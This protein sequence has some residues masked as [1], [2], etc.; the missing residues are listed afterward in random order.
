MDERMVTD[1]P[2]YNL[3]TDPASTNTI[4]YPTAGST[5][6]QVTVGMYEVSKR[7]L[8][9][10]QTGEPKDKYLTNIEWSPDARKIYIAEVNR[11]QNHMV[12][13]CYD[14]GTTLP[15]KKLF[16]EKHV[17]YVEP[18]NPVLFVPKKD[19]QF[20]WQ[21]ERDGYNHLYLYNTNGKLIR[22]L[23]KGNWVVTRILG[24]NEKGTLLFFESTKE[25]PLERHIYSVDLENYELRKLTDPAGT[26]VGNLNLRGDLILDNFNSQSVP[27]NISIVDQMAVVKR[28]VFTA[29]D[30]LSDF[31]LGET[32]ILPLLNNG[33]V[34]YYRI[35][36]PPNFDKNKKYP[37]VDY[38]YGGPHVQLITNTWLGGSNLWMQYMA[39]QGFVVFTIDGRGSANRGFDFESAVHRQLGTLEMDDQLAGV[40]ELKKLPYVNPDKMAVHGWSF[41]GFMTTTLM[42]RSPGTFKVGIAGGPVIDWRLYEIMYTE[43]YMDSPLE[44]PVGYEQSN[45]LLHV[46]NLKNK[47][48]MIHGCDDDVVLW[49]HSLQYC[50]AAVDAGNTWLDYYVYPGHKH[51]VRGKDR[52]HLMDK[53]TQYILDNL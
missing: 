10:L 23:T 37:V 31:Q 41:G 24:I 44:N 13:N 52:I 18:E 12:L 46:S 1:Y 19:N 28:N 48:L 4:K 17:K 39:Q 20:I 14:A 36:T 7:Q 35:I 32:R 53:V 40:H 45:L 29:P 47:L 49:Q 15:E 30:P 11:E 42:T 33:V 26:H 43:R 8:K 22:Q 2:I 5:S 16:E 21:S 34:L 50:K 27:R 25:S 3:N 51:N 9:Y 38:V 6:H